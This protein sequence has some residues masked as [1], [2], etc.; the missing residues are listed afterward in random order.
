MKIPPFKKIVWY[1]FIAS[2]CL[3]S[4]KAATVPD[5]IPP[6]LGWLLIPI[7]IMVIHGWETV[8]RM[9]KETLGKLPSLLPLGEIADRLTILSIK[10]GKIGGGAVLKELGNTRE[11][12]H[13]QF[14]G[15]S[16]ERLDQFFSLIGQLEAINLRQWDLEN[17]VR[18]EKSYS[19]ALAAR[20][21]NTLRVQKK[22]EINRLAGC[23]EEQKEYN[24]TE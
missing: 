16:G 24:G 10:K 13:H 1:A 21:N 18:A 7:L 14:Q 8:R 3:A 6:E 20:E 19:A 9:T 17:Q 11:F 4:L 22:N 15:F 12:M 23:L 2:S 5:I